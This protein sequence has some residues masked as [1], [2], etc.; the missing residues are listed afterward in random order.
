VGTPSAHATRARLREQAE[1][2]FVDPVVMAGLEY[3]LGDYDAM[4]ALHERG[5][6][7]RSPLMVYT[8]P[9]RRFFMS[10]AADDPR[11]DALIRRMQHP[12]TD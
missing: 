12:M 3:F 9:G 1:S 5:F 11:F 10:K 6:E 4:F 2:T 8:L 7:T